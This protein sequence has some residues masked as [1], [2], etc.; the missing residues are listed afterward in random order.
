MKGCGMFGFFRRRNRRKI[1]RQPVPGEWLDMLSERMPYLGYLSEDDQVE[2]LGHTKVLVGEKHFEGCQGLEITDEIRVLVAAQ[3]SLLIL[4]RETDYFPRLSTILVYP[5]AFYSKTSRRAAVGTVEAR[6]EL[7]G[8][9]SWDLGTVILSWKDVLRCVQSFDG[10]NVVLHEFAHQLDQEDGA[11]NG[12]PTLYV[13]EKDFRKWGEV[14]SRE[15]D[16]L[17]ERLR[18]GYE[19]FLDPYAAELPCEFFAVLT[20]YFF[21]LPH[22]LCSEL[23]EIYD[24]LRTLYHFDPAQALPYSVDWR[25]EREQG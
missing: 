2:L 18:D 15:F 22:Q 5:D 21:E 6:R 14:M 7:R 17:R 11:S 9:E 16:A 12:F 23:P 4:H 10:Y 25:P 13:D 24:L 20:E 19:T 3:A 8:G 1:R